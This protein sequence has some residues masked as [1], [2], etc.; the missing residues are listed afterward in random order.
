MQG[1]TDAY[2]YRA[3]CYLNQGKNAEAKADLQK[4]LQLDP[5]SKYAKDAQEFLKD[6]K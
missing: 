6:L 4:L 1:E 5:G 3:L 2:Y